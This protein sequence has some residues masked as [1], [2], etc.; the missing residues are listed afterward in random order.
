M[1]L[2]RADRHSGKRP[3]AK[4]G[5]SKFINYHF[6]HFASYIFNLSSQKYLSTKKEKKCVAMDI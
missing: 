6:A 5:L 2:I 4:I 1:D 3:T